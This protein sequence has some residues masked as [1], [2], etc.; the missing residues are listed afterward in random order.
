MN[1]DNK[2]SCGRSAVG[3]ASNLVIRKYYCNKHWWV[4]TKAVDNWIKNAYLKQWGDQ[5]WFQ[6]TLSK[7]SKKKSLQLSISLI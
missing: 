1:N 3:F 2:C 6:K 4:M 7:K 5:E